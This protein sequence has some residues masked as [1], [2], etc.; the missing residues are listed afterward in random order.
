[1]RRCCLVALL[2]CSACGG[3][4][5]L[6][7]ETSSRA[8]Q[9]ATSA[10]SIS[11]SSLTWDEP[12]DQVAVYLWTGSAVDTWAVTSAG[13]G[14]GGAF[15]R[16]HWD[17]TALERTSTEASTSGR[18]DDQQVWGA[19]SGLA[20]AGSS[21]GLQR[22]TDA[23]WSDWPATP[24]CSK[25]AGRGNDEL[26]C[27]TSDA[28]WHLSDSAWSQEPLG[29]VRGIVALSHDDVWAWGADGARHFDGTRWSQE[30]PGLVRSLSASSPR[31]VWAVSDGDLFHSAG[32]GTAWRRQNPTGSQISAVWSQAPTNTWIVAAGAALRF[33]GSKWASVELPVRDE[34]LLI[35]G[36][37]RDVWLGGTLKLLHARA[38]V[39]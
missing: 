14:D 12:L 7:D 21:Q 29:G 3:R 33:N 10:P 5:A 2:L 15:Y 28:L 35:S 34:F 11:W 30:L 13:A 4:S 6:D 31:D 18:F 20:F 9:P 16:E 19:P 22:F 37:D 25:I 32:P 23:A 1:M 8:P 17:G 39:H 26:W 24:S 27:A 38:R 36:S